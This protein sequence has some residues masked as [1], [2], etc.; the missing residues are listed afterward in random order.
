MFGVRVW[1]DADLE[2]LDDAVWDGM[3]HAIRLRAAEA[4]KQAMKQ[5]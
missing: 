4:R 1:L 5:R 3:K 2:L